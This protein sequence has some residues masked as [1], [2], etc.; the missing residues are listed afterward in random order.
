METRPLGQLIMIGRAVLRQ[1][2]RA[3]DAEGDIAGQRRGQGVE[4]GCRPRVRATQR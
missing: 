4:Y 1:L 2:R 3:E